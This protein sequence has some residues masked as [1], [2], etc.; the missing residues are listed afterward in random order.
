MDLTTPWECSR[1]FSGNLCHRQSTAQGVQEAGPHSFPQMKGMQ[2]GDM[3]LTLLAH[4]TVLPSGDN[5][6]FCMNIIH[7]DCSVNMPS[8]CLVLKLT[9]LESY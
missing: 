6:T 4:M 1:R 5:L 7:D 3:P 9:I 2:L 8:N